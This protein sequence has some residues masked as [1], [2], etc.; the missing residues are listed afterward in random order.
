MAEETDPNHLMTMPDMVN[1]HNYAGLIRTE[2]AGTMI[3]SEQSNSKLD[4]IIID[5]DDYV[6]DKEQVSREFPLPS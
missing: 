1:E 6:I 5:K 2:E 3:N 4:S